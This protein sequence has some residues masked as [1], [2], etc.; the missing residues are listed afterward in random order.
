MVVLVYLMH[1]LLLVNVFEI[2]G[3]YDRE[4]GIGAQSTNDAIVDSPAIVRVGCQA[5]H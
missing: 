2:D 5:S 3:D 1:M 4:P